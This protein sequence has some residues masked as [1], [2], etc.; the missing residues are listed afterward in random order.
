MKLDELPPAQLI[1]RDPVFWLRL[2]EQLRDSD[3]WLLPNHS[4]LVEL[5]LLSFHRDGK[6]PFEDRRSKMRE[7]SRHLTGQLARLDRLKNPKR[8]TLSEWP[9]NGDGA[10]SCPSA[11][12]ESTS[13][14]T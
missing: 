7:L 5:A 10:R 4:T 1:L 13:L 6:K 2:D 12:I 11:E 9:Q 14:S 3:V 8:S